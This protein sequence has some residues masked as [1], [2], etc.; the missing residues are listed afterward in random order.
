[1]HITVISAASYMH[2]LEFILTDSIPNRL[3]PLLCGSHPIT[4]CIWHIVINA[5]TINSHSGYHLPFLP[6]NENHDFHHKRFNVNY[7][8]MGILD[9]LHGT[10]QL[11]MKNKASE[12]NVFLTSFKSARELYPDEEEK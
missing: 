12:R 7:S 1:M 8:S 9:Y 6:S 10:D 3:G 2:P 4:I 11:F 5:Y